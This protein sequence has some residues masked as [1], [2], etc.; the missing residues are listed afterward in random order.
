MTLYFL[1]IL[2]IPRWGSG[3]P[4]ISVIEFSS[5]ATCQEASVAVKK[6]MSLPNSYAVAQTLCV[7]K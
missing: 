3:S 7:K 2:L 1:L 5:L 4:A 6:I